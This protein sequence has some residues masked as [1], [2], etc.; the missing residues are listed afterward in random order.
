MKRKGHKPGWGGGVAFIA[1]AAAAA[2]GDDGGGGGGDAD[3]DGATVP[4]VTVI[5]IL[6]WLR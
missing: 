3:G 4:A 6:H 1:S 5:E 2:D